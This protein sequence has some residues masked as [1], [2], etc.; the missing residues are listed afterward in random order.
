M[1]K[2]EPTVILAG[3]SQPSLYH[4]VGLNKSSLRYLDSSCK[5]RQNL[6]YFIL[7]FPQ[8]S[9]LDFYRQFE[10]TLKPAKIGTG[11]YRKLSNFVRPSDRKELVWTELWKSI[12]TITHFAGSGAVS[13]A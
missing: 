6:D 5:I 7:N 3:R 9:S 10:F 12:A 4:F 11:T 13:R 2:A 8:V 1:A